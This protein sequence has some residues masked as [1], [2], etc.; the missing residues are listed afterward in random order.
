MRARWWVLLLVLPI[1]LFIITQLDLA[2]DAEG[3]FIKGLTDWDLGKKDILADIFAPIWVMSIIVAGAINRRLLDRFEAD[4][5]FTP[6][7]RFGQTFGT[8]EWVRRST[9]VATWLAGAIVVMSWTREWERFGQRPNA[10]WFVS[11]IIGAILLTFIPIWWIRHDLFSRLHDTV[12]SIPAAAR[13]D[14]FL[15]TPHNGKHRWLQLLVFAALTGI[16]ATVVLGQLD[17]LLKGM[18]PTGEAQVGINDLASVFQLDL[19]VK[20]GEIS[21]RVSAWSKYAELVGSDFASAHFIATLYLLINSLLFA[22]SYVIVIGILLLHVRRT[23]PDSLTPRS[24][25]SYQFLVGTA[26]GVTGVVV[27]ADLIESLMTWVVINSA[28]TSGAPVRSWP[29]RLMWFAAMFRTIGFGILVASGLL[30]VAFRRERLR[31][32]LQTLVAV[33][34]ELLVLLFL[35]LGLSLAQTADVIRRWSVSIVLLTVFFATALAMVLFWTSGRTLSALRSTARRAESGDTPQPALVDLPWSSHSVSLRDFVVRGIVLVA[36]LQILIAGLTDAPAGLGF[37]VPVVLIGILWLLGIPLPSS[38]F[39]RGDREIPREHRRIV[40]RFLGALVFAVMGVAVI[41]S[42]VPQLIYARHVDWWLVFLFLPIAL[43]LYRLISE[44]GPYV[45]ALELV[46]VT[47][48]GIVGLWLIATQGNPELSPVALMY[49]GVMILYGSMPFFYSYEPD[50]GPSQLM[51]TKLSGLR[52]Q[53]I[54]TVLAAAVIV[55]TGAVVA[56][57]LAVAGKIGTIA[58]FVLGATVF[59]AFSAAIVQFAERTRPPKIL[60]AFKFNRTP[61]FAFLF[62]W[63]ALAGIAATGAS[64]DVD[65]MTMP[66]ESDPTPH[67]VSVDDAWERWAV[68]NETSSVSGE[69]I[70][71]VFVAS[72]GGGLRAAVWTSYV[73]DCVFGSARGGDSTCSSDPAV[74][75]TRSI[76]VTSGVSGGSLGLASYFGSQVQQLDSEDWVKQ[77]LGDD[78]LAAPMAW[79]LFVDTPRSFIGFGPQIRDRADVLEKAFE[80][81]WQ[82]RDTDGFLSRGIFELWR[83]EPIIPPM[84]FNGTSVPDPCRFNASVLKATAHDPDDTC[85]SLGAFEG[86]DTGVHSTAALSATKDLADYLCDD[87]DIR[88]S[89]ALLLSARFPVVTPSGRIGGNLDVCGEGPRDAYVVDGGYFEGSAAGTINELWD[90]IRANVDEYNGSAQNGSCIVPFLIQIDNGY[91]ATAAAPP[92]SAPKEILVPITSLLGSQFGH[93]ASA[94][95][96]AAITF[97]SPFHSAGESVHVF[98]SDGRAIQSRYARLTT[99]AHPGVQAPLGWTLSSASFD[100]LKTQLLTE[101]N[102]K[103]LVEISRWLSGELTCT[104]S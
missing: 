10:F 73:M 75:G 27:V 60:A 4:P 64:N 88:V 45:G 30:I 94:R 40:P 80:G 81:S 46:A 95:E 92:G 57:P 20:P 67:A 16:M 42:A 55:M 63:L 69:A 25:R 18:H 101:E 37:T 66:T 7:S 96:E 21:Q 5:D 84:V 6:S 24:V 12:S 99:R 89:T 56:F 11:T 19:S 22:P 61:V 103:E 9:W 15:F 1:V 50:S 65:V 28:W 34:G 29:V 72:S 78:Y 93:M 90:S 2:Q 51:E 14:A 3:H 38:R 70:P 91:E 62:V 71:I 43:G 85:T 98:D 79:L 35:F 77:R 8:E 23:Q 53:P 82:E 74:N 102:Q 104:S 13:I 49:S 26:I 44:S 52:V 41:R 58:I 83:D 59:A 54:L 39:V 36:V 97:D 76:I 100:D 68:A 47:G 48:T 86:Q 87:Q 17:S 32:A 33:R 31:S